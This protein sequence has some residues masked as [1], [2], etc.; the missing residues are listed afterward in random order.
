MN[1]SILHSLVGN[2]LQVQT[3]TP[4]GL[5]EQIDAT[6]SPIATAWESFILAGIPL[7][8]GKYLPFV[9]LL[10]VAGAAFFTLYFTFIN[11][12]YFPLAIRVVSGK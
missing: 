1:Q 5:Y 12:R 9:V 10:L 4:I 3:A 11:I 2:L 7:E 8:N 6:F